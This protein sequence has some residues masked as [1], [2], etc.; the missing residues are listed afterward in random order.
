MRI[1]MGKAPDANGFGVRGSIAGA[2]YYTIGRAFGSAL[3]NVVTL[4][5]MPRADPDER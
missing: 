1:N 3:P 5:R 2:R 4:A